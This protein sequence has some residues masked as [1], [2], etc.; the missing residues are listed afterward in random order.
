V[1]MSI[2]TPNFRLN[3]GIN[4]LQ[5]SRSGWVTSIDFS[6]LFPQRKEN[7]ISKLI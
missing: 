1:L 4:S 7:E 5:S 2:I 6:H 3:E